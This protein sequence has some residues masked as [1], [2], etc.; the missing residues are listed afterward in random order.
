MVI[1]PLLQLGQVATSTSFFKMI[2]RKPKK[3]IATLKIKNLYEVLRI[4]YV[5]RT[6]AGVWFKSRS[7]RCYNSCFK[8]LLSVL[9]KAEIEKVLVPQIGLSDGIVHQAVRK[10]LKKRRR[11]S[12]FYRTFYF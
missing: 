2:G 5:R 3:P 7:C 4:I 8:N 9:K 12:W 11:S 6:H 1:N 10:H